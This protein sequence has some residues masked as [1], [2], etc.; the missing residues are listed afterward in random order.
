VIAPAMSCQPLSCRQSGDWWM[1][2]WFH[3]GPGYGRCTGPSGAGP[4]G[5][6]EAGGGTQGGRCCCSA[7]AAAAAS[8]PAAMTAT[9]L[10]ARSMASTEVAP[11]AGREFG[12]RSSRA[13]WP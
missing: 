7:P 11:R 1:R 10:S 9:V 13:S 12:E 2:G 4:G 3:V 6:H 5:R 8:A